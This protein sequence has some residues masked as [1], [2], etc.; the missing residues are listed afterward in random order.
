MIAIVVLCSETAARFAF[1]FESPAGAD[2]FKMRSLAVL[3]FF[4]TFSQL[5]LGDD[6]GNNKVKLLRDV[7]K[8]G[9]LGQSSK[10]RGK[11]KF[12]TQFNG[13]MID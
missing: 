4:S 13:F 11:G 3:V 9:E 2:R 10:R 5:I 6:V 8:A 7:E 12:R 1:A